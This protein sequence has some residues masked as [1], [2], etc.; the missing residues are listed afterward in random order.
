MGRRRSASPDP[1]RAAPRQSVMRNSAVLAH[2]RLKRRRAME[3]GRVAP[4]AARS[5]PATDS[6]QSRA[7]E[8]L[9]ELRERL[10]QARV[11]PS[12]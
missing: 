2:R 8:V 4:A 6:R 12:S 11:T 1:V 9:A 7:V 10:G 3:Q 5:P